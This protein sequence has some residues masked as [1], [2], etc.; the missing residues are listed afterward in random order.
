MRYS[1]VGLRI[2]STIFVLFIIGCVQTNDISNNLKKE[3]TIYSSDTKNIK[4]EIDIELLSADYAISEAR[5]TGGLKIKGLIKNNGK[6]NVRNIEFTANIFLENKSPALDCISVIDILKPNGES[7]FIC[8]AGENTASWADTL[9]KFSINEIKGEPTDIE[10]IDDFAIDKGI[11]TIGQVFLVGDGGTSILYSL[12]V[13]VKFK[14]IGDKV[15]YHPQL[16]IILYDK[17]RKYL[18][19]IRNE[20]QFGDC[21]EMDVNEECF[22]NAEFQDYEEDY[23]LGQ[24]DSVE[25][26]VYS[27]RNKLLEQ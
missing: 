22:Y 1:I 2:I 24:V 7:P 15:V 8:Y 12:P 18:D 21:G 27:Y 14:N 13:S 9:E 20:F 23:D 5:Y 4:E 16:F 10:I 3:E 19:H 17:N 6:T 11:G 25:A 26:K